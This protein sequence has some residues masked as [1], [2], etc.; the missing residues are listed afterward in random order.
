MIKNLKNPKG[1]S[2][3]TT[4]N[5]FSS[6][7]YAAVQGYGV[8]PDFLMMDEII[9]WEYDSHM[10]IAH[11]RDWIIPVS[12]LMT[13]MHFIYQEEF[14]KSKDI[15]SEIINGI[16]NDYIYTVFLKS[17]VSRNPVT[18][19]IN[20]NHGL[21]H[22][23]VIYGY[24]KKNK[25]FFILDF[26]EPKNFIFRPMIMLYSDFIESYKGTQVIVDPYCVK[27]Y[28]DITKEHDLKTPYME[29]YTQKKTAIKTNM[30]NSFTFIQSM[31]ENLI[32][33]IESNKI[34]RGN[35]L[36]AIKNLVVSINYLKKMEYIF[37][38]NYDLEKN[39]NIISETVDNMEKLKILNA[40][41][42]EGKNNYISEAMK[43][44][45]TIDHNFNQLVQS[46]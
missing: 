4:S 8:R 22:W 24:D 6:A 46:I 2:D 31:T 27:I 20:C 36:H 34:S 13:K 42:F 23:I 3:F 18:N 33:S 40:K 1:F 43:M 11:R 25:C 28:F 38:Y 32:T 12:V 35:Y 21:M 14:Y 17:P 7:L 37:K 44:S 10:T 39:L 41:L 5:C 29:F 26:V 15:L 30:I 9:N 19:K 16:D 45:E